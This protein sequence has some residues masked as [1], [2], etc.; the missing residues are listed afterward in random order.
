MVKKSSL[1]EKLRSRWKPASGISVGRGS[2]GDTP[3]R[4][5]VNRVEAAALPAERVPEPVSGRK[6]SA[7]DDAVMAIGE[8]FKE[9]ASLMRGLQV[10]LEDQG[11]HVAGIDQHIVQL[12][13]LGQAQLDML[14][15]VAA[16]LEKQTTVSDAMLRTFG[17]LPRTLQGVQQALDRAAATDV[18][19]A[20]TLDEFRGT[21]DRISGAIGDMVDHSKIHAEAAWKLS[22]ASTETAERVVEKVAQ[23]QNEE[24]AA[25]R[26]LLGDVGKTQREAITKLQT[27]TEASLMSMRRSQEDQ[28]AKLGKLVQESG[29]WNRAVVV[30]LVLSFTALASICFVLLA[31]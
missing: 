6:L 10:R 23:A 25:V 29:K 14:R 9:L 4:E 11:G 30:L 13:A 28:S 1:L 3:V 17:D 20:E 26:S 12:P 31:K 21:M 19:T 22:R 5:G 18:R 16:Q 27:A 15:A 24:T 2:N 8:G 7:K